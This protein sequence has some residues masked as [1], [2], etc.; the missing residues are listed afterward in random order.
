M[1]FDGSMP[2]PAK[3]GE[4]V[5]ESVPAFDAFGGGATLTVLC[6]FAPE[7]APSISRP[8]SRSEL[9]MVDALVVRLLPLWLRI[10]GIVVV[11][12]VGYKGGRDVGCLG[13]KG[14]CR[15]AGGR[16]FLLTS[17]SAIYPA[18]RC[19]SNAVLVGRV[20]RGRWRRRR[21]FEVEGVS[22][23]YAAADHSRVAWCVPKVEP[24]TVPLRRNC[25]LFSRVGGSA[26]SRG[27]G[28]GWLLEMYAC[29]VG[30]NP[31]TGMQVATPCQWRVLTEAESM[32]SH[33]YAPSSRSSVFREGKKVG[34]R[35]EMFKISDTCGSPRLVLRMLDL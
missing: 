34:A 23:W 15:S 2:R 28:V 33:R 29:K 30:A 1:R 11:G 10:R 35:G 5:G 12:M 27:E 16:S 9:V 18:V 24:S 7:S 14:A 25:S 32:C 20:G 19:R 17:Y 3:E 26:S 13:G 21:S 4:S 8:A 31:T 22:Q 6:A